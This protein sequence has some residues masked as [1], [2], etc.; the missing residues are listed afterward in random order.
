LTKLNC[1]EDKHRKNENSHFVAFILACTTYSLETQNRT[2]MYKSHNFQYDSYYMAYRVIFQA[3]RVKSIH[4]K[5]PRYI[6][7]III[8]SETE[9]MIVISKGFICIWK[10]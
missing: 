3:F 6:S 8:V 2:K 4:Y 7:I 1:F 5:I 9:M 10:Q